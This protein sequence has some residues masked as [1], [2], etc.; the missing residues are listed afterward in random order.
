[1]EPQNDGACILPA[2]K[3]DE[4][5][6]AALSGEAGCHGFGA[7][8]QPESGWLLQGGYDSGHGPGA[9][10]RAAIGKQA[11]KGVAPCVRGR[12]VFLNMADV[13]SAQRMASLF[14]VGSP[15]Y[16]CGCD[17]A[18]LRVYRPHVDLSNEAARGRQ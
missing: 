14:T 4:P 8:N 16:R 10:R 7:R 5:A 11:G 15:A 2:P 3:V 17:A 12:M 9:Q 1:M 18:C 6:A 13:K